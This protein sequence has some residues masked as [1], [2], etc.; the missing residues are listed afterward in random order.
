[1][2]K[3]YATFGKYEAI[4]YGT[5]GLVFYCGRE[6]DTFSIPR[7]GNFQTSWELWLDELP[8]DMLR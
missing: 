6:F 5:F 4:D 8:S 2:N 7:D 3:D 1:M